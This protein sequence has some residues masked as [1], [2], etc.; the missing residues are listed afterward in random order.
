MIHARKDYDRFQDPALSEPSLLG[1]GSTPIAPD[2]P[3]I[4]FRAQDK[5]FVN[6]LLAYHKMLCAD[7]STREDII[8]AVEQHIC[9]STKWQANHA[10]KTPDLPGQASED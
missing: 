4:L 5:N 6:I 10:V 9:L 7:L 2:E 8:T 3:V 1:E